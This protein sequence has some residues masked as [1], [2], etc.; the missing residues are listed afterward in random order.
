MIRSMSALFHALSGS[1]FDRIY[2]RHASN[3]YR[4]VYA[5]LGNHADAEDVTQQTFLNA[6][7]A[8]AQGTRPRKVENWLLT[9]AHNEV[10]RHFRRTHGRPVEVELDEE[11]A[12]SPPEGAEPS[13]A[14]VLRALQHLPPA[15]RAALVM[16]EFEGRSYAEIAEIMAVTQDAL[17]GLIFRARRGLAEHLEGAFTCVEAEDAL[18]RRLDGRLPRRDSRRLKAHLR[19]CQACV[20]FSTVQRRQRSLLKGLSILPIPASLYVFRGEQAALAAAGVGTATAASTTAVVGGGAAATGALGL[21]AKAA[22]VAASAA[23]VGGVGYGVS[24]GAATATKTERKAAHAAALE[25]TRRGE[26]A[27]DVQAAHVRGER[28]GPAPMANARS[29]KTPKVKRIKKPGAVKKSV[30]P[31]KRAVRRALGHGKVRTKVPPPRRASGKPS[32]APREQ[33]KAPVRRGRP[34][35]KRPRPETSRAD[36]AAAK[37][38]ARLAETP[39]APPDNTGKAKAK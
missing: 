23:V 17:E 37:K 24:T 33:A 4:Y 3:V 5:V 30:G 34:A 32:V 21:A 12:D 19:E 22:A 20:R 11:L 7:R 38:E 2:R 36:E 13:L 1:S 16:R 35:A 31:V 26:R 6:Y 27:A 10:R 28:P 25:Q 14:D 39:P 18:L 8:M 29:V 15:Q 9:I